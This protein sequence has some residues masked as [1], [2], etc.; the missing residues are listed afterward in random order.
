VFQKSARHTP[1]VGLPPPSE[2]EVDAYL[3]CLE[4]AFWRSVAERKGSRPRHRLAAASGIM[5]CHMGGTL[6][7]LGGGMLRGGSLEESLSSESGQ[8]AW[9]TCDGGSDDADGSERSLGD[10]G[11][12]GVVAAAA[13]ATTALKPSPAFGWYGVR[14]GGS[15]E[16]LSRHPHLAGGGGGDS[17]GGE[18]GG[19]AGGDEDAASWLD[20]AAEVAGEFWCGG[21]DDFWAETA[22]G[23]QTPRPRHILPRGPQDP[24]SAGNGQAAAF[25][26]QAPT[27]SGW[28]SR[29]TAEFRE[30]ISTI[31]PPFVVATAVVAVAAAVESSAEEAAVG[32]SSLG[33]F[34]IS[35]MHSTELGEY[36]PDEC[37]SYC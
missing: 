34:F 32:E 20:E 26:A 36:L 8:S 13:A 30:G 7:G 12:S 21:E 9:T 37:S 17:G 19:E 33:S 4:R 18:N 16:N 11:G 25:D 24:R 29:T 35:G 15:L 28:V 5:G 6:D 31:P 10:G 22:S 3:Q 14:S 1:A 23:P 2:K 27:A